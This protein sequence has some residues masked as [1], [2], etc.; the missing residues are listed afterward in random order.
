LKLGE[1]ASCLTGRRK[2]LK[3]FNRLL[4]KSGGEALVFVVVA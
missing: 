2:P 4:K 3:S 1:K